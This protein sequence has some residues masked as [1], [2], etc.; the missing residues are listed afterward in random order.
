MKVY[1]FAIGGTGARVLRSLAYCLASGMDR[2]PN[3][4]SF[5]PMI[6]DYDK[7]N[8]DKLRTE[9]V[10]TAYRQV[11]QYAYKGV[12]PNAEDRSFFIPEIE[13]LNGDGNY[14]FVFGNAAAAANHSFSSE[15]GYANM[16][17]TTSLTRDLLASLYNDVPEK[18]PNGDDNPMAELNL[19]L[20]VGFRGNPNIGSLVFES[21]KD[22]PEFQKFKH[23]FD[24]NQDRV[25]IISSVFGGTGSSGFPRI[26]DA[27][28]YEG[29]IGFNTCPIGA[30]IVLPYFDVDTPQAGGAINSQV[31]NSKEKAALSYYNVSG[32]FNR[33]TRSYFVGDTD[34]TTLDYSEGEGTQKN[35]AHFA[36]LLAALAV[37]D[38]ATTSNV[39]NQGQQ[40][41][42][43]ITAKMQA[44]DP[45]TLREIGRG[46]VNDSYRYLA[47]MALAFR[48]YREWVCTD[49][50]PA[51]TAYYKGM[52][53]ANKLATNMFQ[54]LDIF[55]QDFDRWLD[56]L[57]AQTDQFKP[58]L[59]K[60]R[61]V[62]IHNATANDLND[63]LNGY[64]AKTGGLFASGSSYK[65]FDSYANKYYKKYGAQQANADYALLSMYYDAAADCYDCYKPKK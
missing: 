14:R 55:T 18:L 32:L 58:F 10:L 37:V 56:E 17:D 43:G 62:N 44:T 65:D 19:N 40:L 28:R 23:Q 41:D 31:F 30:A 16:M 46:E 4:T 35:D 48:Y 50:I 22:T 52:G 49:D 5:V 36:E 8:G 1:I 7:N 54:P 63:Y 2:I 15:I 9:R 38:F 34:R 47:R 60:P 24:P 3:G 27:I 25:F 13:S 45:I 11:R 64:Y 29:I 20:S 39:N 21:L 12:T 57:A 51:K 42:Y 53:L 33:I 26:V 61:N 6:I 59:Q